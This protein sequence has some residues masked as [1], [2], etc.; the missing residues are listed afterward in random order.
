MTVY[1][2]TLDTF[3]T[4]TNKQDSIDADHMNDVQAAIVATQ[5]ELGVDVAG[6]QTNLV[7]R[8]ARSLADNGAMRQ[9]T[10]FPGSPNDGDFFYRTDENVMYIYNGSS[11]DSQGQSLS[12]VVFSFGTMGDG[13]HANN[14][15]GVIL[16]GNDGQTASEI[17]I[18]LVW[19]V[20]GTTYRTIKTSMF[21]KIAGVATVTIYAHV[22][23]SSDT[24]VSYFTTVRV[25]IGGQ[26]GSAPT[27]LQ[28]GTWGWITFDVDVSGLSDGTY[29]VK[30]DMKHSQT[31]VGSMDSIIAFGS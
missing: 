5:T 19:G 23:S 15:N 18:G 20:Y 2:G 12:N 9:G 17:N 16:S 4:K 11:W 8:L 28:A 14:L 3:T 10:S 7:T 25:D 24:N 27:T 22:K 1:P 29:D 21:R 31:R 6:S 26:T 13:N 30:I